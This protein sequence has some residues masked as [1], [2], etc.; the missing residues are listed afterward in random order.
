MKLCCADCGVISKVAH[1]MK[2][3]TAA[4]GS[5]VSV[6]NLEI[7][8]ITLWPFDTRFDYLLYFRFYFFP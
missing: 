1:W 5:L 3:P 8:S 2:V 7:R 6:S 4:D